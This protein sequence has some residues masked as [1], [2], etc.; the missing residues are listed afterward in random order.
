M[1]R[2]NYININ[3]YMVEVYQI[4]SQINILQS[5]IEIK[6]NK[7]SAADILWS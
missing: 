4:K 6:P 1:S 3:K 5:L 7:W 2:E